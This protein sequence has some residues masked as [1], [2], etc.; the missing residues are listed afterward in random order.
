MLS[1]AQL[2]LFNLI[3]QAAIVLDLTTGLVLYANS[4]F[5][6]LT[7]FSAQ[8]LKNRPV[9]ILIPDATP[10]AWIEGE[11]VA[12]WLQRYKRPGISMVAQIRRL[13]SMHPW[14]VL[15]VVLPDAHPRRRRERQLSA[16]HSVIDLIALL[17]EDEPDL[18]LR[19]CTFVI[20][21]LMEA[22]EV[23]IY[24]TLSSEL[25]LRK[26]TGTQSPGNLPE[27]LSITDLPRLTELSLWS[28]GR[29]MLTELHRQA[30]VNNVQY[31]ASVPIGQARAVSG[32]L[33]AAHAA[34][35]PS[36]EE[37]YA[38]LFTAAGGVLTSIFQ[39]SLRFNEERRRTGRLEGRIKI[40]N[41]VLENTEQGVLVLNQELKVMEINPAAEMLLDYTA[42]EAIGQLVEHILIGS[43][44]LMQALESAC[45][46]L[47]T[48]NPGIVMLHRRNGV[49]FPAQIQI[50][51][52]MDGDTLLA[53]TILLSDTS[54]QVRSRTRTQQLEHRA[55][56][57]E[58]SAVF[59]HEVR[60]P[61]NNISTGLQYLE[62]ELTPD[63]PNLDIVHRA[64]EDC[65]RLSRL[66]ASLLEFSKP[67][68]PN[69][70]V[71]DLRLLIQRLMDRWRAAFSR[72]GVEARLEVEAH[73][74]SVWGDPQLLEQVFTNLISNAVDAMSAQGGVLTLRS[75]IG[76]T[77]SG[78]G[79][80]EIMVSD[81]GPGIPDE[82][83]TRI[84]EPFVTTKSQGTGLGLAF[85]KRIVT[86]HRGTITLETYVGGTIFHILLPI[87]KGAPDESDSADS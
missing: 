58:F 82:I 4:A 55:L 45:R 31:L 28:P 30:R 38:A 9:N 67:F 21:D 62:M 37:L 27:F 56:L 74:P 23:V 79:Q 16:L 1:E 15:S 29:R 22:E 87:S 86:A 78:H 52:V 64:R 49:V 41:S 42:V 43:G 10:S 76:A 34:N 13:E 81:T 39:Q 65:N 14:A 32:L 50:L 69:F 54:E 77:V 18:L 2:E 19:R 11:D 17:D 44:Y 59:A 5:L 25:G 24:Q 72:A 47:P 57:G 66:M 83:H 33:V 36:D 85:T 60:N 26:V 7:A 80:I 68:A 40:Q 35:A 71:V 84:F 20:R 3:N 46:G 63:D 73:L 6:R 75:Q 53:I 51:P 8:D 70:E 48:H 61:I 12:I